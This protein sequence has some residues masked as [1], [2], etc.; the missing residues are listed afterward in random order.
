MIL[1]GIII[2]ISSIILLLKWRYNYW[3]RLK[4]P[5][6]KP[7]WFFGNLLENLKMKKQFGELTVEWYK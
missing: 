3:K 4:V 5:G 2:F 7:I 1:S 6:P